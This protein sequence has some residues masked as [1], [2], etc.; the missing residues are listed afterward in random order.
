MSALERLRVKPELL[1][2]DRLDPLVAELDAHLV[3]LS[4][5]EPWAAQTPFLIQLPGSG[6]ITALTLLAALG[7]ITRFPSAKKLVG[8]SGL[9]AGV[10]ASGQTYQTAQITKQG[11]RELRTTMI[12]AASR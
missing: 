9:G 10:H 12:E 11:R 6:V 4:M 8:Y 2:L 1:L 3:H 5:T 7:E